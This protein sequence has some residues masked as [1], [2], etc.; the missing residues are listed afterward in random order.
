M[1]VYSMSLLQLREFEMFGARNG[2]SRARNGLSLLENG[3]P[4]V[5]RDTRR[6]IRR[7]IFVTEVLRVFYLYDGLF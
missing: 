6:V 4:A 5:S 2:L 1:S 7:R 3:T